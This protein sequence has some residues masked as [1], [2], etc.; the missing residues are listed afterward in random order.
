MTAEPL[1]EWARLP[2]DVEGAIRVRELVFCQEQG[3]PVEEEL[4]GRDDEALHLVAIEPE[5]GR[6]IGTLRLLFDEDTAKVGRV[7]VEADWRGMGIASR[8]LGLALDR[9]REQGA[10]RARLAS[11]LEVVGLYERAGFTVQSG[12]FEEAGI[13]HVWM[14]RELARAG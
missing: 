11:Q 12:V 2:A 6:V 14:G 7:A 9:A 8:M 1:I 10:R 5:R 4:D 13:P 3:V